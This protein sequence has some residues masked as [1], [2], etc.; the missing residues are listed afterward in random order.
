[1]ASSAVPAG[2]GWQSCVVSR[3]KPQ[4]E[5]AAQRSV[6]WPWP[7]HTHDGYLGIAGCPSSAAASQGFACQVV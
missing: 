6:T 1:M 4:W 3:A 2:F 5:R 7:R